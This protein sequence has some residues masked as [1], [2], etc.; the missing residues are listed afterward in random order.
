MLQLVGQT[1]VSIVFFQNA[2][3]I[4]GPF[5]I[6]KWRHNMGLTNM[7]ITAAVLGLVI[8]AF[9]IPLAIWGKRSRIALASRYHK[10]AEASVKYV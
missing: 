10:L 8:N 7:F 4:A 3:S 2:L 6:E 1:F 9:A 5:A